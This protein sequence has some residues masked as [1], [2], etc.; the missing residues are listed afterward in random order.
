MGQRLQ[1]LAFCSGFSIFS[2]F[3]AI[4]FSQ[5]VHKIYLDFDV[6]KFNWPPTQP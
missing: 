2:D 3:I 1:I 5:N 6:L 4:H